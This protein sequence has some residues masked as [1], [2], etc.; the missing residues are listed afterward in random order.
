VSEWS[1]NLRAATANLELELKKIRKYVSRS[2]VKVKMSKNL[3]YF[4]RYLKYSDIPIKLQQFP[5]SS[6][7]LHATAFSLL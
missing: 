4:K 7:E 2:K 3:N 6:F 1:T 5:V